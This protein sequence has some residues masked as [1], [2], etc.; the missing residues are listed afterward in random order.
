M[1]N[2]KTNSA[3]C[4]RLQYTSDTFFNGRIRIKQNRFGYRFSIDAVLLAHH[5]RPHK[6]N[7]ILDLGTGCGIMPLILAYRHPDIKIYGVEVQKDLAELAALNIKE[8]GLED[9]ITILHMDM[10]A[11]KH[12]RVSGP[13]DLVISNP[14]FRKADSGRINPN[15]QRAV[16]RHEIKTTLYDVVETACRMLS[17]SGRFVTVYPAERSADILAQMR[18]ATI[19][20]KFLR[21]IHSR[22]DTEAKLILLEGIKGA[23]HGLKVGSPL[24]IYNKD[25]AYTDEVKDMFQP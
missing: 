11:L 20:P 14:P 3:D 15:Q 6:Q 24:I 1:A 5:A 16:A 13:L 22:W 25:G 12:D 4:D 21:M 18:S 7:R 2:D 9:R 8:N 23:R 19:E 17:V 10:K